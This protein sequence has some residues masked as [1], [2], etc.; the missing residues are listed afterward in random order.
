MTFH[1]LH[2]NSDFPGLEIELNNKFKVFP[3]NFRD[4]YEP[5]AKNVHIIFLLKLVY[6]AL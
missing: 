3:G 5:C 4:L 2:L 6:R 1:D